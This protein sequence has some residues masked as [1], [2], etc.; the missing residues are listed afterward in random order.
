[1]KDMPLVAELPIVDTNDVAVTNQQVFDTTIDLILVTNRRGV[2]LRVSPSARQ[3]I[4]YEP[5]ELIGHSGTEFIYY[6]D[7]DA[8]RDQMRQARQG[9]VMRHFDCRYVHKDGRIIL[10]TWTGVWLEKEQKHIFIGRDITTARTADELERLQLVLTGIDT[11]L[12]QSNR[13]LLLLRSSDVRLIEIGVTINSLWAS[14]VLLTGPS[15]FARFPNAFYLVDRLQ[16]EESFWGWFALIAAALKI[17]SL[18]SVF[19]YLKLPGARYYRWT[20]L[21][22]SGVFWCLMGASTLVGNPDT[23]F[24]FGGFMLGL[25]SW[26]ALVRDVS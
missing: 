5:K 9:Q 22:M 4:G 6:E 24:G 15:N 26:W 21:S 19:G 14:L 17:L 25:A 1:M 12:A 2:Y 13:W 18:S 3:I 23:L 10:L 8:T 11:R 7:L 20:G 16:E